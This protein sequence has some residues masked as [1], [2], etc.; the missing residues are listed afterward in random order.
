M[1]KHQPSKT[2]ISGLDVRSIGLFRIIVGFNVIYNILEY[3]LFNISMFYSEEGIVP[4]SLIEQNY[5]APFSLLNYLSSNALVGVFFVITLLLAVLYMIGFKSKFVGP[6]LFLLFASIINANPIASHG[7]EFMIEVA[8]FWGFFLPLDACFSVLPQYRESQNTNVT[9]IASY[10]IL[11]QITLIYLTSFLTKTGDLWQSGLTIFTLTD[12]RTHAVGV[13]DWLAGQ[14]GFCSFLSHS[15]LYIELLLA[16]LIFFPLFNRY[17][18]LIAAIC[19]IGLHSGLAMVLFVGPFHLITLAFAVV[20][21]PTFVWDKFKV[22]ANKNFPLPFLKQSVAPQ[23]IKK[24][25]SKGRKVIDK[26]TA[27]STPLFSYVWKAI[28]VIMLLMITQKNLQK[29]KKES[30]LSNV[31]SNMGGISNIADLNPPKASPFTGL[32]QQ[33]WWLFAPNPHKDMGTIVL[34]ARTENNET[35]DILS[36]RTLEISED[37]RTFEPTFN[38]KIMNYFTSSRFVLSF[39]ARRYINTFPPELFERWTNYEYDRWKAD[40]PNEKLLELR[41]Y[42][43]S[44]ATK[45]ER[46]K[47]IRKKGLALMHTKTI[48]N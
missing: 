24:T 42:Y 7:V 15:A 34:L 44:N 1:S 38:K 10:G 29:W 27:P 31:I 35:L 12:D 30:Y 36:D 19:I 4:S 37:P 46:G 41:M 13:A 48:Q 16:L 47:I 18:R 33:P 25:K 26:K 8:L 17:C 14:P 28:V 23:E 3:R 32:L 5:G 6:A 43:Y 45:V 22:A 39:Y 20:L 21:L 9:G 2:G 11:G 40:H